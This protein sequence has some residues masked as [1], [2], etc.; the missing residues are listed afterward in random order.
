[1]K[2]I[3]PIRLQIIIMFIPVVDIVVIYFIA[4]MNYKRSLTNPLMQHSNT[5]FSNSFFYMFLCGITSTLPF[6]FFMHIVNLRPGILTAII[7]FMQVYSF[8]IFA[9]WG[10]IYFQKHKLMI[11]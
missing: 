7:G 6:M 10:L 3:I 8:F 5:R 11:T 9:S 4:Y 2:K 1:M